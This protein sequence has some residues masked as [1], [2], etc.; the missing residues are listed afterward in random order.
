MRKAL[1]AVL[2]LFGRLHQARSE[3]EGELAQVL[4][5]FYALGRRKRLTARAYRA[6]DGRIH[7]VYLV[8]RQNGK[9]RHGSREVGILRHLRGRMNPG[10]VYHIARDYRNVEDWMEADECRASLNASSAALNLALRDLRLALENRFTKAATQGD[11][12]LAH[13]VTSELDFLTRQDSQAVLGAIV[14][15]RSL[16]EIEARITGLVS[17]WKREFPHLPFEPIVRWRKR[18]SLRVTWSFV[19]RFY[20]RSGLLQV[21]SAD[22]PGGVTD[23]WLRG[24]PGLSSAPRRKAMLRYAKALRPLKRRYTELLLWARRLKA[25]VYWALANAQAGL[26]LVRQEA[27]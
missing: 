9:V 12:A 7:Q 14:F 21:R 20:D 6:T 17:E 10:V 13:T 3:V 8:T 25:K 18:G 22:I 26:A 5:S 27:G 24:Q 11:R 1:K 2:D 19:Q 4:R 16:A 23:R 15:D